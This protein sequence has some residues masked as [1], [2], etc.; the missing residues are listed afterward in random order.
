MVEMQ[1]QKILPLRRS[2]NISWKNIRV[3][4]GRSMLVTCGIVLALAFLTY[5]LYSDAMLRHAIEHGSPSLREVLR[6]AGVLS[7]AES[8]DSRIQTRWMVGLALLISFVGILNAMVMSVTE[9]FREIGTMK[10]L[11]ALDSL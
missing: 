8:A 3:R 10:C 1:R 5:V 9:R 11:G 4:W 7:I 6:K 2:I